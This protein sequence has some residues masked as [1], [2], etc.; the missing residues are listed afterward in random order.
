MKI[1]WIL[2][3]PVLAMGQ[4]YANHEVVGKRIIEFRSQKKLVAMVQDGKKYTAL[5]KEFAQ[6]AKGAEIDYKKSVTSALIDAKKAGQVIVVLDEKGH[7]I[8]CDPKKEA[9]VSIINLLTSACQNG[10]K[11]ESQESSNGKNDK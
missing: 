9:D 4:I 8:T 11:K 6:L 2:F 10:Y 1:F 7:K 5:D 3:I